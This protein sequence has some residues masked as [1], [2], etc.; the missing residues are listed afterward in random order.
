[1]QYAPQA[2]FSTLGRPFTKE[3]YG[4]WRKECAEKNVD[5]DHVGGKVRAAYIQNKIRIIVYRIFRA[6]YL[7]LLWS[8]AILEHRLL[9]KKEKM[10]NDFHCTARYGG[11][12]PESS[13]WL[14]Q[15][16]TGRSIDAEY[17]HGFFV[18]QSL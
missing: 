11:S 3:Q 7:W 2:F 1:M 6:R 12:P 5:V 13:S 4:N 10:K 14:M 9:L 15:T 17:I 16:W 18:S 8:F